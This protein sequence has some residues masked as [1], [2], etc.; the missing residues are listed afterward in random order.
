MQNPRQNPMQAHVPAAH[1][2]GTVEQHPCDSPGRSHLRQAR[3]RDLASTVAQFVRSRARPRGRALRLIDAIGVAALD[4]QLL[5]L[6]S[7]RD[8]R[9]SERDVERLLM[10][11]SHVDRHAVRRRS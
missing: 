10:A 2:A 6:I 7:G 1:R 5:H 11:T 3:A 4:E 9:I 8:H